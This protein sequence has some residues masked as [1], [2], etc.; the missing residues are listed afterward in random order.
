M[1]LAGGPSGLTANLGV[2]ATTD[3]SVAATW[4]QEAVQLWAWNGTAY[5][6]AAT[7]DPPVPPVAG[8]PVVG[9][10][11]APQSDGQGGAFWVL[12]G[13]GQLLAYAYGPA[14]LSALPGFSLSVPA[15]PHPPAGLAAGWAPDAGG[16]LYP[17]GWVYEDL[18]TGDTFGQDSV[19]T[20]RDRPGLRTRRTRRSNPPCCPLATP[21]TTCAWRMPTAPPA[22]RR[23]TA[24]GSPAYPPAHRLPTR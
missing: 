24:P 7:W 17:T 18:G 1:A 6:P 15:D 10:A 14:G 5:A 16:V 22:R 12:T 8:G 3:G 20:S 9:V 4:K 21:W 2:A 19:R 13:Q 11:F 23:R